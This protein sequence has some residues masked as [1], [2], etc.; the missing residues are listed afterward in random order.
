MQLVSPTPAGTIE[1]ASAFLSKAQAAA[2]TV[3]NQPS[4]TSMNALAGGIIAARKAAEELFLA[5][6]R[7]EFQD[8]IAARQQVLEGQG[9]LKQAATLIVAPGNETQVSTLARD[10][11]N[12]FENVF[13]ILEND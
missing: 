13:E 9:L 1:A 3:I 4:M 10:A 8:L 2:G 5:P 6:P 11:W 7:S 12:V